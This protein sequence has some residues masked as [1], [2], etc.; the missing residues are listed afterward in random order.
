MVGGGG[1][2]GGVK[3]GGLFVRSVA[4]VRLCRVAVSSRYCDCR[5]L[6]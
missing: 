2:G 3:G 4:G 1:G 6:C 5:L